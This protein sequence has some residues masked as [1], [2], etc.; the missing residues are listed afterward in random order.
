MAS[1]FRDLCHQYGSIV[2][3]K[4]GPMASP[5]LFLWTYGATELT[6]AS[7]QTAILI[8]DHAL[9]KELLEKRS[10]KYSSRPRLPYFVRS[11]PPAPKRRSAKLTA[12]TDRKGHLDPENRYWGMLPQ[13]ANHS[14]G[15]KLTQQFMTGVKA[16]DT[17]PLQDF[18]SLLTIQRFLDG[19]G[20][21]WVDEVH[22]LMT[23]TV[24]TVIYGYH[25]PIG[26]EPAAVELTEV[27][28]LVFAQSRFADVD[29]P[30]PRPFRRVRKADR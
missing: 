5:T 2:S 10:A 3:L 20:E 24:L 29:D 27:R 25:C 11:L 21:G 30:D 23:S 8:G 19:K 1:H 12:P 9:A 6:P 17:E 13:D 26:D 16:G 22:R 18:E 7:P 14:I 4:L 15:R 28:H